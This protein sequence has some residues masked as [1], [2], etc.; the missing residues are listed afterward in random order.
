[1][2]MPIVAIAGSVLA[3][4]ATAAL[5]P[6]ITPRAELAPRQTPSG[7]DPALVGWVDAT[8]EQCKLHL[9]KSHATLRSLITQNHH[10]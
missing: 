8:N 4:T 3:A 1:M 2:M 7:N 10:H 5:D 6:L 9:P